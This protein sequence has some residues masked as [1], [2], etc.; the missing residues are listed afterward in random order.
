MSFMTSLVLRET[1]AT[2]T[3]IYPVSPTLSPA[4][5]TPTQAPHIPTEEDKIKRIVIAA[6]F[7]SLLGFIVLYVLLCCFD[8]LLGL[9]CC[10]RTRRGRRRDCSERWDIRWAIVRV[11]F[12]QAWDW[13][14][15]DFW[16]FGG[17]RHGDENN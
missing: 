17:R 14:C 11:W 10:H 5:A 15:G 8:G 9:F 13:L 16:R 4:T 2:Q 1:T 3:S 7:C 12:D 6:V